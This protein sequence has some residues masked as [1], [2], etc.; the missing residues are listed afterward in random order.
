[1][2]L[3][4]FWCSTW[5]QADAVNGSVSITLAAVHSGMN[6]RGIVDALLSP[7]SAKGRVQYKKLIQ[8]GTTRCR[9]FELLVFNLI[10]Q[11]KNAPA[12]AGNRVTART[13]AYRV[14]LH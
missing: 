10:Y 3:L 9:L 1:M 4:S 7:A 13:S 12:D 2:R 6:C 14:Y 11:L 5:P 8:N